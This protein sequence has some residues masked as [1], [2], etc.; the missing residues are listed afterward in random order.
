MIYT[1]Y[2]F[3]GGV[4]RSMAL[5]SLGAYFCRKGLRVVMVDWDLE[6]PG[7]EN[8]FYS[9]AEGKSMELARAAARPGLIDLLADYK[10]KFPGLLLE[11]RL[12]HASVPRS[13]PG[14]NRTRLS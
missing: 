2:S 10:K 5:A 8:Y 11:T 4:G 6:A 7:L 3:K 14:D 12:E 13:A 9:P 1:L